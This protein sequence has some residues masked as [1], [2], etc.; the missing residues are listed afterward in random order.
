MTYCVN[1]RFFEI[2][3]N[4]FEKIYIPL[5]PALSEIKINYVQRGRVTVKQEPCSGVLLTSINPLCSLTMMSASERPSPR[6][7]A[8]RLRDFSAR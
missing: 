8:L 5:I 1:V 7:P 6:P 2:F 3:E 4:F